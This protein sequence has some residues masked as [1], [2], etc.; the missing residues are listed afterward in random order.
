MQICTPP[1]QSSKPTS[2]FSPDWDDTEPAPII[3]LKATR[4]PSNTSSIFNT[5][6]KTDSP[7][8]EKHRSETP[9]KKEKRSSEQSTTPTSQKQQPGPPDSKKVKTIP[10]IVCALPKQSQI[11]QDIKPS[12][13][14]QKRSFSS[15][16]DLIKQE[17]GIDFREQKVRKLDTDLFGQDLPENMFDVKPTKQLPPQLF[18]TN[19]NSNSQFDQFD[20]FNSIKESKPVLKTFSGSQIVNGIETNPDYVNSLLQESLSSNDMKFTSTSLNTLNP[21]TP[22]S[23]INSFSNLGPAK[24]LHDTSSGYGSIGQIPSELPETILEPLVHSTIVEPIVVSEEGEHHHRNKSKKKKDK[25]KHKDRSKDKEERSKDKEERKKHKKDKERKERE[26]DDPGPFKIIF[27]K[28]DTEATGPFKIKIPKESIRG[29][30]NAPQSSQTPPSSLKIKISKDK[31]ENYGN[32]FYNNNN[33][34]AASA[35]GISGNQGNMSSMLPSVADAAPQVHKKKDREKERKDRDRS[36]GKHN[37][38]NMPEFNKSNGGPAG[39]PQMFSST[40]NV[41]NNQRLTNP[42]QQMMGLMQQQAQAMST[43]LP[44]PNKV[45][46]SDVNYLSQPLLCDFPLLIDPYDNV[47]L[48]FPIDKP[49]WGVE[50]VPKVEL[51]KNF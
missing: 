29:D 15:T 33:D 28:G 14:S 20:A 51:L 19:S 5:K 42:A 24:K 37:N 6:P 30:L 12:I 7:K 46:A 21:I 13:Q 1:K 27:S 10:N 49:I 18:N 11:N 41:V 23:S 25:H 32:K 2:I 22:L 50:N 8:K 38:N 17:D 26:K 48:S 9:H 43:T 34:A 31:F 4:P 36:K 40:Q 3:N 39:A 45:S 35:P 44:N 47:N 16:Q